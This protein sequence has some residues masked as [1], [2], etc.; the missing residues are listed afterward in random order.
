MRD[1]D[2][3]R[4]E[5]AAWCHEKVLRL[6][7]RVG[8]DETV[9]GVEF[10]NPQPIAVELVQWLVSIGFG[11]SASSIDIPAC[12]NARV[13]IG[14]LKDWANYLSNLS[15]EKIP[16]QVADKVT[17]PQP[18]PSVPDRIVDLPDED[19]RRRA[20][21][22]WRAGQTLLNAITA[23][24]DWLTLAKQDYAATESYDMQLGD[25]INRGGA[26]AIRTLYRCNLHCAAFVG[27]ANETLSHWPTAPSDIIDPAWYF[28][29]APVIQETV[30]Y[31]L[32]FGGLVLAPSVKELL[33]D[34]EASPASVMRR[35]S[36]GEKPP[37]DDEA[38][39]TWQEAATRLE[40]LRLQGE[41]FTSQAK[42]AAQLKCSPSTVNRAI[43]E[44]PSLQPWA[45]PETISAPKAQS[46]TD[47]VT[48]NMAQVREPDPAGLLEK[49][50]VDFV[51][52]WLVEQV[53]PDERP[54]LLKQLASNSPEER[55][56]MAELL[57]NDPEKSD[58]IWGRKA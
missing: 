5:L 45:K 19:V 50:D 46:L 58:K 57:A 24:R 48:D 51:L 1:F 20:I 47:M 38:S 52:L 26:A 6:G 29:E 41:P 12:T 42:L 15:P 39:M 40:R 28:D 49:K 56:K 54:A 36:S 2:S 34:M 55:Q 17:W 8:L 13:V 3:A 25:A 53:E 35:E 9:K 33:C 31:Q 7:A 23:W 22:A 4:K 18:I 44:T 32:S 27:E 30:L 11:A 43:W 16:T 14:Y 10:E 21:E 37:T